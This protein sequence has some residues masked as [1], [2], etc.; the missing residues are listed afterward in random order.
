MEQKQKN[1]VKRGFL[2]ENVIIVYITQGDQKT[3]R[4]PVL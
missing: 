4:K 2:S 3:A 1:R